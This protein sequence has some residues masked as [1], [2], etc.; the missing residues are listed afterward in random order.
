MRNYNV[1]EGSVTVCNLMKEC[2]GEINWEGTNGGTEGKGYKRDTYK[3]SLDI[4]LVLLS[5]VPYYHRL[6]LY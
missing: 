4:A 2:A 6:V 3:L 5:L 1:A